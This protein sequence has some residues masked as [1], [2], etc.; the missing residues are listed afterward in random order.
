M[1]ENVCVC[2]IWVLFIDIIP[3]GVAKPPKLTL[4]QEWE[5]FFNDIYNQ[6]QE[7]NDNLLDSF[8]KSGD[9]RNENSCLE[10]INEFLSLRQHHQK[11]IEEAIR[12]ADIDEMVIVAFAAL[13]P[14]EGNELF[15]NENNDVQQ[16][17]QQMRMLPQQIAATKIALQNR[18]Q[19]SNAA[20]KG[21]ERRRQIA[22][23]EAMSKSIQHLAPPPATA[24][25]SKS[26][27]AR[28]DADILKAKEVALRRAEDTPGRTIPKAIMTPPTKRP[29]DFTPAELARRKAIQQN[30]EDTIRSKQ[31]EEIQRKERIRTQNKF[32]D[33]KRRQMIRAGQNRSLANVSSKPVPQISNADRQGLT[34]IDQ[35]LTIL[36]ATNKA[37]SWVRIAM[38]EK[39]VKAQA[40][41]NKPKCIYYFFTKPKFIIVF[42]CLILIFLHLAIDEAFSLLHSL[43]CGGIND[44]KA[45]NAYLNYIYLV[46]MAAKSFKSEKL[47][48][49][50]LD[51][52]AKFKQLNLSNL[53][54]PKTQGN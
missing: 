41:L 18:R 12:K 25:L 39:K 31:E 44:V 40:N 8:K 34:K 14:L 24:L 47:A 13:A 42:M 46:A 37:L 32:G 26:A 36:D 27:I 16:L 28:R 2:K 45:L 51:E 35:H 3:L 19:I 29:R 4:E 9:Q 7:I 22:E 1:L 17:K 48:L 5:M 50:V 23:Q 15:C 49:D 30:V 11:L 33:S 38:N 21:A 43:N 52:L 6:V 10:K 54:I 53:G 20:A